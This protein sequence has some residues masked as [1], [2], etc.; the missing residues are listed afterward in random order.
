[1]KGSKFQAPRVFQG[2]PFH[3]PQFQPRIA[4]KDIPIISFHSSFDSKPTG[5]ARNRR[6]VQGSCDQGLDEVHGAVHLPVAAD[7]F[8]S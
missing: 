3:Q 4:T 6:G 2:H 8:D 7:A 5:V 1:M